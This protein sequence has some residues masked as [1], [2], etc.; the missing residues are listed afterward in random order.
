[1]RHDKS[2]VLNEQ[3]RFKALNNNIY[4]VSDGQANTQALHHAVWPNLSN[5]KYF[6]LSWILF[7]M[8]KYNQIG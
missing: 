1:M 5:N 4:C 7:E 2:Y 8:Q 6:Y 3:I